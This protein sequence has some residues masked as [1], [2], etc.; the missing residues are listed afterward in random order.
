MPLVAHLD[1]AIGLLP[2]DLKV[3][4]ASNKGA[5]YEAFTLHAVGEAL[6]T[7]HGWQWSH[8]V[9]AQFRFSISSGGALHD[10]LASYS[11]VWSGPFVMVP[12]VTVTGRSGQ[13]HDVDIAALRIRDD[14]GDARWD[15]VST[16]LECKNVTTARGPGTARDL[17]GLAAELRLGRH[18]RLHASRP[19]SRGVLVTAHGVTGTASQIL[20]HWLLDVVQGLTPAGPTGQAAVLAAEIHASIQ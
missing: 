6:C 19:F 8:P 4:L 15:D 14:V 10:V 5:A 1:Q 7:N 13:T 18:Y 3:A 9:G 16:V 20:N 11:S 12:S 17:V 2:D